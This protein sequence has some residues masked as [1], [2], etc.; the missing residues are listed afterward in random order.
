MWG[1]M[2]DADVYEAKRSP[3]RKAADSAEGQPSPERVKIASLE[4]EL[5]SLRD[6]QSSLP[7][8]QDLKSVETREKLTFQKMI[9]GMAICKF[10]FEPDRRNPAANLIMQA[11]ESIRLSLNDDTIREKLQEAVHDLDFTLHN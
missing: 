7:R 4:K 10:Q 1:E 5:E 11:V 3:S 2:L 6:A 9:L 8:N